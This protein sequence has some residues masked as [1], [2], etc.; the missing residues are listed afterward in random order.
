VAFPLPP[1]TSARDAADLMA[2][3]TA[4]VATGQ[5]TP[6]ET[7]EIGKVIDAYVKAHRA[8]ELDEQ[9]ALVR[10]LS[11]AE[12]MRIAIGGLQPD[13]TPTLQPTGLLLTNSR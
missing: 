8:A 11:D 7:M 12:L 1:I 5:I 3:V 10:Q 6:I 13:V 2:A 9:V 4:A